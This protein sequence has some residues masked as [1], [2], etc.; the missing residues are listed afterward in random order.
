MFL[1]RALSPAPSIYALEGIQEL[2]S[3]LETISGAVR[4]LKLQVNLDTSGWGFQYA[5]FYT[6]ARWYLRGYRVF[7]EDWWDQLGTTQGPQ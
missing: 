5:T 6:C 4:P 1:D 3:N 7:A 2:T